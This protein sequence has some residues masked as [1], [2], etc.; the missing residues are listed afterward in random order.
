[1]GDQRQADAVPGTPA[2]L[3]IPLQHWILPVWRRLLKSSHSMLST[4]N[5][6]SDR[7][8]QPPSFLGHQSSVDAC[9]MYQLFYPLPVELPVSWAGFTARNS[10]TCLFSVIYPGTEEK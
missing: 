3:G 1:M 4:L 7:A 6:R 8:F 2:A 9:T 5:F 10:L